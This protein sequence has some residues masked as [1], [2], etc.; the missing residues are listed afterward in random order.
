M[1]DWKNEKKS[2]STPGVVAQENDTT[3]LAILAAALIRQGTTMSAVPRMAAILL[4]DL[5]KANSQENPE[6][7]G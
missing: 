3:A 5:K 6:S 4:K 2:Y 1:S 7:V